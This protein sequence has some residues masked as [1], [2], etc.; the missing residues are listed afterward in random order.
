[1][2]TSSIHV[3]SYLRV[4]LSL[5]VWRA[6]DW[7]DP[8]TSTS[9]TR[10]IVPQAASQLDGVESVRLARSNYVD[11]QY[12]R[13]I[14]PQGASQLDSVESVRLARSNYVDEQYPRAIVPQGASQLDS[15]ESVRLARPNYVDEQYPRA[16]ASQ[17]S[18][19]GSDWIERHPILVV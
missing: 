9:F 2:S 11:E 4:L 13:A 12:P 15:V 10:A 6:L 3:P 16:I 18:L 5:M 19:V 7:P 14:V 1:M 17:L 8:I